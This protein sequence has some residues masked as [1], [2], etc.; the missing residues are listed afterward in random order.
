MK[1]INTAA[2][3]IDNDTGEI[4]VS[5]SAEDLTAIKATKIKAFQLLSKNDFVEING[6]LK[7][8]R[9]DL[10][11]TQRLKDSGK[12]LGIELLDHVIIS[13]DGFLSFKDE[14]LI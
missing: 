3:D 7:P 10:L 5:A 13:V 1:T 11:V 4:L 12:L 8:S 14:D 2:L 6:V 9:E